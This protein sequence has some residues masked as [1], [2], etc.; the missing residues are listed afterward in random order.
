MVCR[1]LKNKLQ[2]QKC[3]IADQKKS[4]KQTSVN[5]W[6]IADVMGDEL[7]KDN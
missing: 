4:F 5:N 1:L 2:T 7:A 3:N 6:S